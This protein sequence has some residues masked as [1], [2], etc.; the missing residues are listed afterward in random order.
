[1]LE[2]GLANAQSLQV[3]GVLLE[4]KNALSQE[5]SSDL[6]GVIKEVVLK[7]EK[8]NN[9]YQCTQC[10]F[11]GNQMH[12]MCPSCKTWQAIHPAVEYIK[13]D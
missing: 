10:G 2:N 4:K 3:L 12:W 9:D 6:L 8:L 13:Q 1:M 11:S 7:A 5:L